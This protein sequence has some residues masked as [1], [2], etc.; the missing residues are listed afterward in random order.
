MGNVG[1]AVNLFYREKRIHIIYRLLKAPNRPASEG[2]GFSLISNDSLLRFL[3]TLIALFGVNTVVRVL[4]RYHLPEV[5]SGILSFIGAI[6]A[7]ELADHFWFRLYRA[8]AP[9]EL[10]DLRKL[11]DAELFEYEDDLLTQ[12]ERDPSRK[13]RFSS[14]RIASL[15]LSLFG[16]LV[17]SVVGSH[18]SDWRPKGPASLIPV[19]FIFIGGIFLGNW[20]W[21]R[22]GKSFR[23]A[24][25]WMMHYWPVTLALF[26]LTIRLFADVS[27][28]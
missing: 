24:I 10:V 3:V 25:R 21:A 12:A 26:V 19:I 4:G 8:P 1:E 6:L 23:G 9:G 20:V 17:I 7:I 22:S 18:L 16:M 28:R 14:G 27:T 13:V 11:S 15:F 2:E 5:A